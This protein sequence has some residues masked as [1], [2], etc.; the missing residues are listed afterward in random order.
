MIFLRSP[1]VVSEWGGNKDSNQ[2]EWKKERSWIKAIK[3]LITSRLDSSKWLF[4]LISL[5]IRY[6]V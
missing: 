6:V 2:E 4:V 1:K 3:S 5:G